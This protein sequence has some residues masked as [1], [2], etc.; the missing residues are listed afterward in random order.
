VSPEELLEILY[1][2]R[3]IP[4]QID[5]SSRSD[6]ESE[7]S[8]LLIDSSNSLAI[9]IVMYFDTNLQHDRLPIAPQIEPT[10]HCNRN[11]HLDIGEEGF[12]VVAYFPL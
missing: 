11:I 7:N 4:F 9:S 10:S 12:Y 5:S 6:I 3:L 2:F 1:Y 8:S